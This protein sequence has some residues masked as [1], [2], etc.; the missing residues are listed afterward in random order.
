MKHLKTFNVIPM[1]K[2]RM[3]KAD[4]WKKRPCVLKYWA[5]KDELLLQVGKFVMPESDFRVVFYLPMPKSWSKK[6][7]LTM[8]NKP[9]KQKPDVDNLLKGLMDC[10]CK[11]D[12]F[13]WDVRVTK[14]WGDE[15]QIDIYSIGE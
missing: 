9:H 4:A 13:I 2:P 5:Y 10:L 11:E 8:I 7:K 6:F 15:G 14:L 1:G 12:K 3:N